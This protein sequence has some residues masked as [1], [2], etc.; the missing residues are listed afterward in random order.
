MAGN[1]Y[2]NSGDLGGLT[3]VDPRGEKIGKVEQVWLDD[4]SGK[5]EWVTIKTGLFG[6]KE[7]F[8]PLEGARSDGENLHV[9]YPKDRVKDA[10]RIEADEHLD[11]DQEHDLYRHYSLT[12]GHQGARGQAGTGTAGAAG[13]AAG[14]AGAQDP[15]HAREGRGRMPADAGRPADAERHEMLRS[16]ERLHV[17]AREREVGHARLR[18]VVVTENVT[19]TV[20]ISHEEVRVVR[21]PIDPSEGVRGR[22]G[23][24]E[25]TEVT[26][27]AEQ[28]EIRKEAV[29][30]ER[31]RLETD[32]VTEQQE[33]SER[34]RKEQ[35]EYDDGTERRR[36]GDEGG[37][38]GP[39]G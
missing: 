1:G 4:H 2:L 25:Q 19:T 23:Q 8:V 35:V 9:A 3:A 28:A 39:R 11:S 15:A 10:P 5:P 34:V 30:V 17:G 24:E 33:V 31:V 22:I 29:P 26:L 27:H 14:M 6:T 18:K 21:E 20:P 12:D 16:E 32:K 38:R 36:R 7:T 37:R 13:S